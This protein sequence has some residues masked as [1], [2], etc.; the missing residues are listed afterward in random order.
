MDDR[1][2]RQTSERRPK[3]SRDIL[4]EARRARGKVLR[5][6]AR[7]LFKSITASAAESTVRDSR[8][9][10]RGGRLKATPGP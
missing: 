4:Q 9:L 7:A 2:E 3:L 8:T 6:M 1:A 10:T 5:N